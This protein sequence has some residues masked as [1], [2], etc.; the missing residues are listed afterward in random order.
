MG[1]T[2]LVCFDLKIEQ[3]LKLF[4]A[5]KVSCIPFYSLFFKQTKK[6][7]SSVRTPK[8]TTSPAALN[9]GRKQVTQLKITNTTSDQWDSR[10]P[11][12]DFELLVLPK[13]SGTKCQQF[14][15]EVGNKPTTRLESTHYGFPFTIVA[16]RLWQHRRFLKCCTSLAP[17]IVLDFLALQVIDHSTLS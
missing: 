2:C 8:N 14:S 16:K 10:R 5:C 1:T 15:T 17:S 7:S 11:E 4:H 3:D 13:R 9:L 12:A 6:N